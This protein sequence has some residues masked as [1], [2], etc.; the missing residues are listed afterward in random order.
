MSRR[1]IY[2]YILAFFFVTLF[3]AISSTCA[4]SAGL[5]EDKQPIWSPD[6][7]RIAF[8]SNRLLPENAPDG[9]SNIWVVDVDGSNMQQITYQGS[10]QFPSWSPDG[11]KIIFQ[12]G[13]SIWQVDVDTKKFMQLAGGTRGWYA[14]DWHPKNPGKVVCAYQTQVSNDND[15]AVINPMTILTRESGTQTVRD[16]P[17]SDD[18]PRWSKDGTRI[19]FIGRKT[20]AAGTD[21]FYL[22]TTNPDGT[23]LKTHCRLDKPSGRPS[24][25]YSGDS[26]VL[27]NGVVCDLASGKTRNLFEDKISDP[28][29]SPDGRIA[30]Y[31]QTIDGVGRLLFTRKLSGEDKKQITTSPSEP[32]K[33]AEPAKPVEPAV[34][35]WEFTTG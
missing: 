10:N 8:V 32:A 31:S 26:I 21:N 34:K 11:Q 9:S 5:T 15:L 23:T 25:F 14:P 7:K 27:D 18:M 16:R 24:W 13:K 2:S 12:S 35:D 3:F 22:M 28:D 17:G 30:A 4:R 6:G 1:N 33:P 19:A 20:D 29:I